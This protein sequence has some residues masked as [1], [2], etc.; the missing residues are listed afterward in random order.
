[1]NIILFEQDVEKALTFMRDSIHKM[2][3]GDFDI[4]M[5]SISKALK[6]TTTIKMDK[7]SLK[8][9][10]S[11]RTS[12]PAHGILAD[13]MTKRDPGNAPQMND[14]IPYV[15]VYID[16]EKTRERLNWYNKDIID[17]KKKRKKLLQGDLVEH[18]EYVQKNNL[19]LDYLIYLTNQLTN[20]LTQLFGIFE[21][22]DGTI[23]E[24]EKAFKKRVIKPLEQTYKNK[25][26]GVKTIDM[27]FKKK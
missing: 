18:P 9:I 24:K 23:D 19:Q 26:M 14:R 16:K 2:F 11:G 5:F 15:Y 7:G 27:F 20:P 22:V 17:S 12:P 8:L 4:G 21:N 13:R 10:F 6:V 1:L 3:K 25:Q